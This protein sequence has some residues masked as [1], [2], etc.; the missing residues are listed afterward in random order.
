MKKPMLQYFVRII[1]ET[2]DREK[3]IDLFSANLTEAKKGLKE[4]RKAYERD[5]PGRRFIAVL[6]RTIIAWPPTTE[7]YLEGENTWVAN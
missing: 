4:S 1:D 3:H 5:F 6:G 7:Y 2:V